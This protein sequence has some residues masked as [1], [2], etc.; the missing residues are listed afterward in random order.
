MAATA[1]FAVSGIV[2]HDNHCAMREPDRY[3]EFISYRQKI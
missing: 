3:F 1:F 2:M